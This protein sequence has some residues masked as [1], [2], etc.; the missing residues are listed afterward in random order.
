M[1]ILVVGALSSSNVL[2]LS[3]VSIILLLVRLEGGL[4]I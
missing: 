1:L 3:H 4:S 2:V